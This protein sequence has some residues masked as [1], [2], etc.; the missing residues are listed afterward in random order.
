MNYLNVKNIFL[1]L[2]IAYIY[3]HLKTPSYV[4]KKILMIK[5]LIFVRICLIIKETKIY[6][7][8]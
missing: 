1:V 7:S 8:Y 6:N 4:Y 2:S 5:K 3:I